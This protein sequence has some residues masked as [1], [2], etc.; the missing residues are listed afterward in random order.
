MV[1]WERFRGEAQAAYEFVLPDPAD[2]LLTWAWPRWIPIDNAARALHRFSWSEEQL[3]SCSLPTLL[4]WGRED[5]T[6]DPEIF[7][8][9]FKALLPQAEGPYFVTGRHFLQE[10]SGP[11]IVA[12][13]TQ[14]VN[15]HHL[16]AVT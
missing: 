8:Q 5:D 13:I 6:F 4:I 3:K 11:E 7:P 2:R 14:F 16:R 12:R 15:R 9:R 1:D 10:D